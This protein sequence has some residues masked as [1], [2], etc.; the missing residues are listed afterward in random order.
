[1]IRWYIYHLI[2]W[3]LNMKRSEKLKE[4]KKISTSHLKQNPQ[5][6]YT[7]TELRQFVANIKKEISLPKR[8]TMAQM[9]ETI[10]YSNTLKK[11]ELLFPSK[12]Y[13]RYTRGKKSIYE[14][15][16]S[17]DSNAYYSHLSALYFHGLLKQDIFDIYLN[18]E[19]SEKTGY[20]DTMTQEN[21]DRAFSMPPRITSNVLNYQ[22]WRVFLL[23]GKYTNRMSVINMTGLQK[24]KVFVTDIERTLIDI[25]VR[26][27]YSGGVST[28]LNA[29]KK[30]MKKALAD[31]IANTLIKLGYSYPYHQSIGFYMENAGFPQESNIFRKSFPIK[32]NFYLAHHVE[33]LEY[34]DKW[35][36]FYPK[37]LL[38]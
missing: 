5:K 9:I 27:H 4:F 10:E 17:L 8:V 37:D 20:G 21:I 29:Y 24:K 30:A 36:I 13:T 31:K 14:V 16:L 1:M 18:I 2:I 3:V 11:I 19:Q 32:F 26:P 35:K 7:P 22:Q 25:A 34:S 15:L 12:K 33:K 38:E 28:V 23:N 6:I